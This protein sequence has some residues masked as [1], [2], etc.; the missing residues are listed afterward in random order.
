MLSPDQGNLVN[1]NV[2]KVHK[3]SNQVFFFSI[4]SNLHALVILC[5]YLMLLYCRQYALVGEGFKDM[6]SLI[7]SLQNIP[8]NQNDDQSHSSPQVSLPAADARRDLTPTELELRKLVESRSCKKC[9]REDATIV[10]LPCGHLAA[11]VSCSQH[12]ERCPIASCNFFIR[13]KIQ[14]VPKTEGRV[15]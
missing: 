8:Q 14:T 10:F 3:F 4:P 7:E 12:I 2:I 11:C 1:K 9:R 5:I 13:E 15:F 6:I